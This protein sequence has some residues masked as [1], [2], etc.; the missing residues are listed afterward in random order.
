[1][2]FLA[3]L[4]STALA[5]AVAETLW[6]YPLLET[7]HAVGMVMLLGSLGLIDLRVL[8]Y[9]PELPL[10]G[11]QTLLRLAWIG[12][13]LNAISGVLLFASDAVHFFGSY[14]FRIKLV[15][16][17][18]AGLNA[19]FVS[20]KVFPDSGASAELTIE[21]D[22]PTKALAAASLAFWIGAVIAG[23]LIAYAP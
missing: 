10:V 20:R 13:T 16:I 23:R 5:T 11:M 7:L 3:W 2:D 15:L 6:A 9:E 1:M 8:G 4:E 22:A 12:F 18:L 21:T 17:A 14:T 19:V